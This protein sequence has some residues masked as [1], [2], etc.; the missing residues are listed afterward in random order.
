MQ[1]G[2]AVRGLSSE[3]VQTYC[4]SVDATVDLNFFMHFDSILFAFSERRQ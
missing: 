4:V 3:M 2:F 1:D